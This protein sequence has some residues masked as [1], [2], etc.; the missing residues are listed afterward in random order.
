MSI[1][2][3][4]DILE[5]QKRI[6]P[7]KD[8]VLSAFRT[9]RKEFFFALKSLI[10]DAA[11]AGVAGAKWIRGDVGDDV[12]HASFV[13]NDQPLKAIGKD[14]VQRELG[15]PNIDDVLAAK[16]LIYNECGD[17]DLTQRAEIII[18]ESF[19]P[20]KEGCMTCLARWITDKGEYRLIMGPKP[21]DNNNQIHEEVAKA[22]IRHMYA[23]SYAWKS[24]LPRKIMES[25]RASEIGFGAS[26]NS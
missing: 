9:F 5:I 12:M 18:S 3:W 23:F 8:K 1:H 19:P 25:G 24:R 6:D 15:I 10:E 4:D 7:K 13:L 17:M 14:I 26:I 16:I 21:M 20:I 2:N 22:F 11:A